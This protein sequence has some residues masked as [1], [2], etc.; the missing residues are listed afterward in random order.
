MYIQNETIMA[1]SWEINEKIARVW[2]L[3]NE[4]LNGHFDLCEITHNESAKIKSFIRDL[5]QNG[6]YLLTNPMN[7]DTIGFNS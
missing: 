4:E 6:K 7:F 1:F 3:E 5:L 2:I